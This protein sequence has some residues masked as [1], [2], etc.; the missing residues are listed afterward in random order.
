[1][2]KYYGLDKIADKPENLKY[3]EQDAE[4]QETELLELN[5]I[6][7]HI[8]KR[9][10]EVIKQKCRSTTAESVSQSANS[11]GQAVQH[12]QVSLDAIFADLKDNDGS[13]TKKL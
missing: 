9:Q 3:L 5:K 10:M 4:L 13:D 2:K 11:S 6:R 8:F 7:R 12:I 1:M